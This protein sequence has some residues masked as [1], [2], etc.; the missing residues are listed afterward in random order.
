MEMVTEEVVWCLGNGTQFKRLKEDFIKLL[1][2]Q[3]VVGNLRKL[4][5]KEDIL[6]VQ[7]D[8]SI[9]RLDPR[10]LEAKEINFYHFN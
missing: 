7:I 10:E 1:P 8:K 5:K 9:L 2:W 4:S 3:E 6:F